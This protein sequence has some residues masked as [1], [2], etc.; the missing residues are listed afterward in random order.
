MET[1]TKKPWYQTYA[2]WGLLVAIAAGIIIPVLL[3]APK[4][5][6][7]VI[8]AAP[9]E[10]EIEKGKQIQTKIII[11]SEKYDGQIRLTT[12]SQY[13][14]IDLLFEPS[15]GIAA[16]SFESILTINVSSSIDI[17]DYELEIIGIGS[18]N[19]IEHSTSFFLKV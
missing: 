17:G 2:F 14:N 10:G 9:F 5:S 3:N 11:E 12:K 4:S 18:K 15:T 19:K 13:D 7:F 16:P 6:D 8:Y 1:K